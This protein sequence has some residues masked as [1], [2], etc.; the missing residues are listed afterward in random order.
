MND[1]TD[2]P[3]GCPSELQLDQLSLDEL[4][5][6]RAHTLRT[7]IDA[8]EHCRPLM[9]DRAAGLEAFPA[10]ASNRDALVA[11]IEHA[12]RQEP[13]LTAAPAGAPRPRTPR[14]GWLFG[15]RGVGALMAAA[16]AVITMVVL[17]PEAR[18][19]DDEIRIK[20]G[21][22]LRIFVA[23]DDGSTEVTRRD[24]LTAGDRLRFSAAV[25]P[26]GALMVVGVEASGAIFAYHPLD[27]VAATA[28]TAVNAAN[29][30]IDATV[31]LDASKGREFIYLVWCAER[32]R[33]A[34]LSYTDQL[35]APDGCRSD[36]IS[37]TK[38]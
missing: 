19:S 11:R 27:G 38:Q 17:A 25:P 18:R 21:V 34:D 23:R 30:L 5:P 35:Q 3:E 24:T 14:M 6:A 10:L 1:F 16:A 8:C 7:H 28:T 2:R 13:A 4:E 33:L 32:F 36:G 15:P 26:A 37:V 31:A 9:A 12:H 20:G 29:A 22:K